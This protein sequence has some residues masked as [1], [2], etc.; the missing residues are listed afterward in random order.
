[1]LRA[2]GLGARR[3]VLS[4]PSKSRLLRSPHLPRRPAD[5]DDCGREL[6]ARASSFPVSPDSEERRGKPAGTSGE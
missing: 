2:A 3:R 6:T 4:L 5:L 1:M